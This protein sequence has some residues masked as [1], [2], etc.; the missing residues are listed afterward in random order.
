MFPTCIP[1]RNHHCR[2]EDDVDRETPGHLNVGQLLPFPVFTDSEPPHVPVFKWRGKVKTEKK[3]EEF[4][5]VVFSPG[6]RL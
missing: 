1:E 5:K 4:F 2:T 6:K 3:M